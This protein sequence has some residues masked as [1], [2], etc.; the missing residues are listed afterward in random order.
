MQQAIGIIDSGVGGLTV[1]KEIMRQLPKEKIVYFGD[2]ARCPYGPRPPAEVRTF[3]RQMIRYLF[4]Y[5]LK[6]LVIACNTATAVVLQEMNHQAG[7]PVIGVIE[8]GVRSAIEATDQGTIAVIGTTGTVNSGAYEKGIKTIRPDIRV[9][10]HPCPSLVPLVESGDLYSERALQTV[11]EALRPLLKIDFDTLILGCTHYPLIADL[12]QKAVGERVSLI[13]SA[14]ATAR[15]VSTIL[16]HRGMLNHSLFDPRAHQF[17]T[18]G[19]GPLFRRI[20]EEW[21]QMP[22]TLKQIDPE[23]IQQ[24]AR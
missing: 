12:I 5:R 14:E 24:A 20:A 8:P 10:S 23:Q 21:L 7:M 2:T 16:S 9:L 19:E 17:F 18:S 6:A 22:I 13:S 11:K 4:Q 3:S 15:E 1:A